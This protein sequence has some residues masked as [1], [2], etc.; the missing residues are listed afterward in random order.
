MVE[1][2]GIGKGGRA[3]E[4]SRATSV[5][6]VWDVGWVRVVGDGW[7]CGMVELDSRFCS[8]FRLNRRV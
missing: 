3:M 6:I 1:G 5:A 7:W 2:D 8:L 4:V